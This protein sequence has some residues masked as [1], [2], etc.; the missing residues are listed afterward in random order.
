MSNI[1][2]QN[3]SNNQFDL[4]P[5]CGG[6]LEGRKNYC[7]YCGVQLQ[8][9]LTDDELVDACIT[10]IE[11]M[12]KSL[13]DINSSKV[14]N[15]FLFGVIIGPIALFYIIK[16][17]GGSVASQWIIS[18][19]IAFAGLVLVGFSLQKDQ[20]VMFRQD[21]KPKILRFLERN[22]MR[23]EEFLSI[24]KGVLHKGSPF[25]ENLDKLLD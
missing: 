17:M 22:D 12:N 23:S 9:V 7:H 18:I 6:A 16:Y 8:Q 19:L 5:H 11:S 15:Y 24:A 13:D 3:N 10:L 20:E 25:Y 21:F 2:L 4:C 1:E 14:L